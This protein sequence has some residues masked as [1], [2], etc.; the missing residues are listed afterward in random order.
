[1]LLTGGLAEDLRPARKKS[2]SR[3]IDKPL[4]ALTSLKAQVGVAPRPCHVLDP[5]SR[6][7]EVTRRA[8]NRLP[9]Y[10]MPRHSDRQPPSDVSDKPSVNFTSPHFRT[11]NLRTFFN[12]SFAFLFH[13]SASQF[14]A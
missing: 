14:N 1:M 10:S 8:A 5:E 6:C 2:P 3:L 11:S 9:R 4:A 13:Q 7:A 12:T